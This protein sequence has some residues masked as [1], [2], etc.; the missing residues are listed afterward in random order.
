MAENQC[1]KLIIINGDK[2]YQTVCKDGVVYETYRRGSASVLKFE[3]YKMNLEVEEGNAVQFYYKDKKVFF[4]FIFAIEKSKDEFIKI[5]AYD[6]LRYLKN[7]DTFIYSKTTCSNL[8]KNIANKFGLNL[9]SI[10]DTRLPVTRSEDGK[11]LFDII[12]NNL[13]ETLMTLG[14]LYVLYDDF[15]KLNLKDSYY[16]RNNLLICEATASDFNYKTSIDGD[17]YNQIKLVYENEEAGTR[18]V[19][20][21]KDSS[22]I[23]KWG[24]LQF[25]DTTDNPDSAAEKANQLLKLYNVKQKSLS[26]KNAL[27]DPSVRA[28]FM[29]LCK[30]KI[31]SDTTI[32][33]WMLIDKCKQTFYSD[34]SIMD[35]D[36]LGN[37]INAT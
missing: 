34:Y 23:N 32:Q 7:K 13:D 20:M 37:M 15:G 3:V 25:Y 35:L 36:L 18:D 5:T 2:A 9:G 4:G 16:L 28:G 27:G 33:N 26:I 31:D 1:G 29:L 17:T 6:Q 22:N 8:L 19:Y 30:L 21:A 14:D 24:L 12:Q 10:D 11:T